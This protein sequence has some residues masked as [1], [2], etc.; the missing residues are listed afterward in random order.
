MKKRI[1]S[2]L[3]AVGMVLPLL[4]SGAFA[5]ANPFRDVEK[6]AYYYDA[7]LWAVNHDPQITNG[8]GPDTFSPGATCTRGQVVT[9]LW[10]AAGE[11][12]PERAANP[13]S[14][15]AKDADRRVLSRF[16]AHRP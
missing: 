2:I 10:R 1:F 5:A 12:E 6:G 4:L 11:P 16:P 8:T 9:F 15:V 13:F 7:V 3:L 14:D